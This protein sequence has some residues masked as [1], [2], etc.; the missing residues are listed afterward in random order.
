MIPFGA[1]FAQHDVFLVVA[2][3]ALLADDVVHLVV[4]LLFILVVG[5]A[6]ILDLNHLLSL[7]LVVIRRPPRKRCFAP[8]VPGAAARAWFRAATP[9]ILRS[10]I[11]GHVRGVVHREESAHHAS[12]PLVRGAGKVV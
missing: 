10:L 6:R 7:R 5:V 12:P 3:E 4:L 2:C 8:F 11:H 9:F 1:V